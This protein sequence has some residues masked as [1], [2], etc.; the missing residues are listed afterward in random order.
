MVSALLLLIP[1]AFTALVLEPG[2]QFSTLLVAAA[3][4]GFG[5]GNFS[6]SM[7][8]IDSFAFLNGVR[9]RTRPRRSNGGASNL[10]PGWR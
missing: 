3:L 7:A 10:V 8:N 5:G 1:T 9:Q 4:A 2:V 6:S